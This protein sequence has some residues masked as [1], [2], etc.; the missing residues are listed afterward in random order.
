MMK[1]EF[2][3]IELLVLLLIINKSYGLK[4]LGEL[5]NEMELFS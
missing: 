5:L 4:K 3:V 2:G 1:I